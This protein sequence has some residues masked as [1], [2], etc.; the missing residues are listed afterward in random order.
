[1]CAGAVRLTAERWTVEYRILGPVT[2]IDEGR[3]VDLGGL[4][5]RVLLARLLLS[6]NRVVPADT[7][8]HDLWSGEPPQHSAATLRVYVSRLRRALG[9]AAQALI[10]APPGY[11]LRVGADELDAS[12]FTSLVT[13]ALSYAAAGDP[14]AAAAGLRTALGLWHGEALADMADLPFARAEV[15]RLDEARLAA[16]ESRVE[17]D[18]GCGRHAELAAELDGLVA[19]HPLRERLSAQRMLALYRCGRQ[20]DALS[21]YEELREHLAGELGIDPSPQLQRLQLAVLRQDPDL[22]GAPPVAQVAAAG[23]AEHQAGPAQAP[24]AGEPAAGLTGRPV[25]DAETWPGSRLPA[26][27]TSFIG[28]E[29]ELATIDE[30]LSL[31]RL[32]T[33]TGPGGSGKSRLAL[34]AAAQ[35]KTRYAAGTVLVELAPVIQADLVIFAVARALSVAEAPSAPLLEAVTATLADRGLLLRLDNCEHLLDAV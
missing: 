29:D 26:Q 25:L 19:D 7:L 9:Q 23:P 21:A 31:S 11:Q 10:T 35:A 22:D 5:E 30:L 32:V 13:S 27:T 6:A 15:A 24:A 17:A 33:L 18:L 28:R 16:T 4:R 14:Q 34:R 8:A 1:M 2:A 20:A 12:R 3:D